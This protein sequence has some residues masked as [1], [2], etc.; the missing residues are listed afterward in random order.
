MVYEEIASSIW[1]LS[2]GLISDTH[3]LMR[4]AALSALAG[5]QHIIHAGDVGAP[6]VLEALR[7]LAPVTVVRGNN[8]QAPWAHELPVA[9]RARCGP[10]SIHVIHDIAELALDPE[11]GRSCVVIYGH[12]HH[13]HCELRDGVWYLNPGSAGPRRFKLP[14]SLARLTLAPGAEPAFELQQLAT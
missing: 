9:V 7:A 8:D 3:G 1:P 5:C 4:P 2:I 12:S 10:F 13:S 14:V 11:D 6:E